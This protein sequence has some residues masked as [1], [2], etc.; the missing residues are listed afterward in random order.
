[1]N[2]TAESL[3]IDLARQPDYQWLVDAASSCSLPPDWRER[4]DEHGQLF[5]YQP[6]LKLSQ[7]FHPTLQRFKTLYDTLEAFKKANDIPRRHLGLD[8]LKRTLRAILEEAFERLRRELPPATPTMVES[9]CRLFCVDPTQDYVMVHFIKST[10]ETFTHETDE[11]GRTLA[12]DPTDKFIPLIQYEQARRVAKANEPIIRC[13]ECES[14]CASIKCDTCKDFFCK[15][16]YASTHAAG[17]RKSH[18]TG[19]IEQTECSRCE[20]N[21]ASYKIPGDV[22]YCED[23]LKKEP[24]EVRSLPRTCLFPLVCSECGNPY[25]SVCEDCGDLFCIECWYMTHRKG[26]RADHVLMLVDEGGAIWRGGVEIDGHKVMEMSRQVSGWVGFKNDS[27]DSYWYH[28]GEKR[29]VLE[30]PFVN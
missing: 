13:T 3:G 5:Y 29:K 16:C 15:E 11:I 19:L 1:M 6:K 4:Q 7:T 20:K 24:L 18:S 23:C 14:R 8:S 17:K 22:G 2:R 25:N 21:L 12:I 28:F 27:L 30:S 9:I 10:L 26:K